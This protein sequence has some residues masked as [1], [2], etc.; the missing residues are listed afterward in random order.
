MEPKVGSWTQ[1]A[2]AGSPPSQTNPQPGYPSP[3]SP[4]IAQE[5]HPMTKYNLSHQAS[6][7]RSC[8]CEQRK[9]KG[10]I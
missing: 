7:G 9:S 1:C 2:I 3:P 10:D 4:P 5:E 6:R 8:V